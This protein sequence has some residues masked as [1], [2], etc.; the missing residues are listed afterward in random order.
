MTKLSSARVIRALAGVAAAGVL[1]ACSLSDL[2][3]V[4]RPSEVL[5]PDAV[6]S[7]TGAITLYHGA[8]TRFLMAF[9]G[10]VDGAGPYVVAS[11]TLADEYLMAN[12]NT[13][14]QRVEDENGDVSTAGA[15][16]T[17]NAV[18]SARIST[19]Q[20]VDYLRAYAPN[21][22]KAY[23]ADMY[24]YRGFAGLFLAE[25]FCS[26][27][28][29]SGVDGDGKVVYGMSRSKEEWFNNSIVLFDSALAQAGDSAY[30]QKLSRL[31]R[32]RAFMNLGEY[33]SAM[34]QVRDIDTDYAYVLKYVNTSPDGSGY[35]TMDLTYT[36]TRV[37]DGEGGNGLPFAS[38][39]DPRVPLDSVIRQN[40]WEWY[41]RVYSRPQSSV[42]LASGIQA[43]L[44]E[45]EVQLKKGEISA[46]LTT[47]NTLRTSCTDDAPCP[48]PAPAGTGKVAGLS[49]LTDP[50]TARARLILTFTEKAFWLFSQGHRQGDLR[51]LVT[52]YGVPQ[53]QL[54]PVGQYREGL[55]GA[56]YGAAID[57]IP[58]NE[59]KYNPAN[60][61]GCLTRD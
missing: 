39:R 22:P 1:Q 50:G 51:R 2:V 48:S 26:G 36:A 12:T 27:V 33:D 25:F 11:G 7:Y 54:Y 17:Y 3:D 32:A 44:I 35:W 24:N 20:A 40:A 15:L 56:I 10:P 16:P 18:S 4:K 58:G 21:A 57:A 41:P 43:R 23:L 47:L 59:S 49:P 46:W 30:L 60:Y 6:K 29:M 5:D 31:G 13:L 8:S 9:F 38:A 14:D 42:P 61:K 45:A 52:Q 53:D 19:M 55:G 28:P 34:A 37:A